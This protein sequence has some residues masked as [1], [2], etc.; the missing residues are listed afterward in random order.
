MPRMRNAYN[1][2]PGLTPERVVSLFQNIIETMKIVLTIQGK[3]RRT[4]PH[5]PHTIFPYDGKDPERPGP[6]AHKL[7]NSLII[8]PCSTYGN[9]T[10]LVQVQ[11]W[12][13]EWCFWI[14]WVQAISGIEAV[15]VAANEVLESDRQIINCDVAQQENEADLMTGCPS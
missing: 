10:Y 15:A 4:I 11:L 7:C 1:K 3:L 2:R 5:I 8:L 6:W 12:Q 9:I 13:G 14:R